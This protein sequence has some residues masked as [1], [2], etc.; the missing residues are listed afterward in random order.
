MVSI[1]YT[2]LQATHK[3]DPVSKLLNIKTKV[4]TNRSS[5][6]GDTT[7]ILALFAVFVGNCIFFFLSRQDLAM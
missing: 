3:Q 7:E 2:E 5:H 1:G 6:G 4:K